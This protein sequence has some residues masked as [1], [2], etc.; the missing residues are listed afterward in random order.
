M[1]LGLLFLG[2]CLT[3]RYTS[4]PDI[5]IKNKFLNIIGFGANFVYGIGYGF[6]AQSLND[7]FS[8]MAITLVAI[9]FSVFYH[10]LTVFLIVTYFVIHKNMK[11]NQEDDLVLDN[12][13]SA[14]PADYDYCINGN[15][16]MFAYIK[17]V[18]LAII[19]VSIILMCLLKGL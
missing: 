9:G 7:Q 5:P 17:I 15:K 11:S 14:D 19:V 1:T 6:P 13:T 2:M 10:V 12:Y 8:I 18:K 16:T 4:Q 3:A